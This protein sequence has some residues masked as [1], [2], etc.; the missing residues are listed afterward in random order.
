MENVGP[1][2]GGALFFYLGAVCFE[3]Q[4]I[5]DVSCHIYSC[6]EAQNN[7]SLLTFQNRSPLN[8]KL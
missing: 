2:H 7:Q 8:L 5:F 6:R 4:T 1:E 3:F